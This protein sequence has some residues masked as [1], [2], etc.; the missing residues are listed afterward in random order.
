MR[1]STLRRLVSLLFACLTLC[2][3]SRAEA[4]ENTVE[5]EGAFLEFN[6]GAT[7][8]RSVTVVPVGAF[9]VEVDSRVVGS[10]VGG[11]VGAAVEAAV[12]SE[13]RKIDEELV[14]AHLQK[15]ES[16]PRITLAARLAEYLTKCF[17]TAKAATT[18]FS[19]TMNSEEWLP[20]EK[21]LP[22][23]RYQEPFTTDYLIETHINRY[24]L[25]SVVMGKTVEMG[26][27]IAVYRTKDNARLKKFPSIPTGRVDD[28][29]PTD[30]LAELDSAT[31]QTLRRSAKKLG[32][33]V[34]K[35][36]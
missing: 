36:I 20:D 28:Y 35:R 5:N 2:G 34:C 30:G 19:P 3:Y 22:Q 17:A 27:D 18:V 11:L 8:G 26:I 24:T 7:N 21:V 31:D 6:G 10:L 25:V 12:T 14:A 23:G 1:F 9:R 4:Q 29:D 32:E 13:S 33:N 16:D 15:A